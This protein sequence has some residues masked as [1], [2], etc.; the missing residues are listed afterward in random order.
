M[1]ENNTPIIEIT[2]E[3]E[4]ALSAMNDSNDHLFITGNAGT[5]KSTLLSYFRKQRTK[6][7]AVL[8]PTGVSALHVK[9]E[10]IHSFFRF[11]AN[12]TVEEAIRLGQRLQNTALFEHLD[13]I[14]IDEISMV[15]A[16][17]MDC[18]DQF[19][20]AVLRSPLPFG[21]IQMIWLGDLYQLP[22]VV[23]REEEVY[24]SEVYKT[25][26]FFSSHAVNTPQFQL[27]T[28]SLTKI[29][30]QQETTFISILNAVRT[31]TITGDQLKTLNKRVQ[32]DI[33]IIKEKGIYL[34]STNARAHD[35][36]AD[37]LT[38]LDTPLFS[39]KAK[40][41]SKFDLKLAPT[42]IQL[43]LK[44]GAQVMFV[45]NHP[46]G[47]WVNGTLG[48]ISDI[49]VEKR[50]VTVK[51]D[52]GDSVSVSP[53]QW[54]MYKHMF[55]HETRTLQKESTGTFTQFPLQLAWAV[56]IHKSQ[57][58]TFNSVMIDM[59]S[60]AFAKGQTYVAL[61]RCKT[62]E[63]LYLKQALSF[64]DILID[65]AVVQFSESNSTH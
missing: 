33:D 37:A 16:D 46:H 40:H 47:L 12:I 15:R 20:R 52:T 14:V 42:N 62:L 65:P 48:T 35:I 51:T 11:K 18:I 53:H 17:L 5:G 34:T 7:I 58:K 39:Y 22:P 27:K 56:T 63:G 43:D 57:G 9:G 10:T 23:T 29:Y 61:S 54:Q 32:P 59:G 8:S 2:P 19:L 26:Y 13:T 21:G 4:T 55:D 45:S 64:S 25:P 24:F 28:L 44:V 60:G 1:P 31:G 38:L 3:F 36:N 6:P 41:S 50:I 49:N 30:R